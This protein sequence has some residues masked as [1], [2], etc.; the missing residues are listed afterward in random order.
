MTLNRCRDRVSHSVCCS[1]I[2]VQERRQQRLEPQKRIERRYLT[3]QQLQVSQ[4]LHVHT[5]VNAVACSGCVRVDRPYTSDVSGPDRVTGIAS[6]LAK[7]SP[8]APCLANS[9]WTDAPALCL[10]CLLRLLQE[11]EGGENGQ[12]HSDRSKTLHHMSN[13]MYTSSSRVTVVATLRGKRSHVPRYTLH[14]RRGGMRGHYDASVGGVHAVRG[15]LDGQR[16]V[17]SVV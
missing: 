10:D 1:Q 13:S 4:Q 11:A 6:Y 17:I 8:D 14:V 15:G 16:D 5:C 9:S 12:R 3:R 2:T 7:L